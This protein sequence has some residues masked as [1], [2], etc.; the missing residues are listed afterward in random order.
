MAGILLCEPQREVLHL[1][2]RAVARLGHVPLPCEGDLDGGDLLLVDGDDDRALE[3]AR[4]LRARHP[5]LPVVVLSIYSHDD[6]RTAALAPFARILKPFTR[7][8][9]ERALTGTLERWAT[10]SAPTAT[11][12]T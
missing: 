6:T 9:L 10:A 12:A 7:A 11:S 1:L 3:C 8:E 4:G 2:E 5:E